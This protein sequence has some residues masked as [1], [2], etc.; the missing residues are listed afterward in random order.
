MF[1]NYDNIKFELYAED[2]KKVATTKH[3]ILDNLS[4]YIFKYEIDPDPMVEWNYKKYIQSGGFSKT[5]DGRTIVDL[6]YL[7]KGVDEDI[8]Q[9][10]E[11]IIDY[12]TQ[13]LNDLKNSIYNANL[14]GDKEY[15]KTIN[16]A[17]KAELIREFLTNNGF[18]VTLGC[19]T[20][21]ITGDSYQICISWK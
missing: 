9:K 20:R 2:L 1:T 16:N 11:E 18:D 21:T 13:E 4:C 12:I 7:Q 17:N 14:H 3:E 6:R 5:K 8:D 10:V 19:H 15:Y